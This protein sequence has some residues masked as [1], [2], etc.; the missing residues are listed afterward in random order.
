MCGADKVEGCCWS[1]ARPVDNSGSC[2]A[3]GRPAGSQG[4]AQLTAGQQGWSGQGARESASV[5]DATLGL[6][7]AASSAS[8]SFCQGCVKPAPPTHRLGHTDAA[9]APFA[10]G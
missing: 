6:P 9:A 3:F 2:S 7:P 10:G 5:L 1:C 8:S 4:V